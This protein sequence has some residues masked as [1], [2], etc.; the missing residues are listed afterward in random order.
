MLCW[1]YVRGHNSCL[2]CTQK[3]PFKSFVMCR[4]SAQPLVNCMY[5]SVRTLWGQS[6]EEKVSLS[7]SPS[8]TVF[9]WEHKS[10]F[11]QL[12]AQSV[13]TQ[14]SFQNNSGHLWNFV[15]ANRLVSMDYSASA[16]FRRWA[17]FLCCVYG[18][19]CRRFLPLRRWRSLSRPG[20]PS[21]SR[22]AKIG[23]RF[24][25]LLSLSPSSSCWWA[26]A[27]SSCLWKL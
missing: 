12:L 3:W 17:V 14:I 23:E 7:H 16:P 15:Y 2:C 22:P 8:H 27:I 24:F 6:V 21:F 18:P 9:H 25:A 20:S 13:Q 5:A 26:K 1:F 10:S 4:N 19:F 11:I